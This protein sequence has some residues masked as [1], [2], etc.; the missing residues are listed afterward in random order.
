MTDKQEAL[1][2]ALMSAMEESQRRQA[3][4]TILIADMLKALMER[5]EN[6]GDKINK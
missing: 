5:I 6:E 4:A 3:A 2:L 1:L